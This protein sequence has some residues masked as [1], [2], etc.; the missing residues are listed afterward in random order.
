M[1]T[2]A[3]KRLCLVTY[4]S[5]GTIHIKG[6]DRHWRAL[7]RAA[8]LP[9]SWWA[10]GVPYPG[11]FA[12]AACEQAMMVLASL[13]VCFAEDYKQGMD[14]AG[15]M[16]DMQE[17]GV[18]KESFV[19]YSWDGRRSCTKVVAPLKADAPAPGPGNA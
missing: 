16:R 8:G 1:D 7:I 4:V 6:A 12:G 3:P 14:P 11:E 17:R 10:D 19:A 18:M 5:E 15:Q 13:G 9:Y 2:P